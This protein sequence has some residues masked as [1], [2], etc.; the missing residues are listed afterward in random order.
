VSVS[1]LLEL[2]LP[3][4]DVC[5]QADGDTRTIEKSVRHDMWSAPALLVSLDAGTYGMDAA[6]PNNEHKT[7]R[8]PRSLVH[9]TFAEVDVLPA[10]GD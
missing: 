3:R 6:E 7:G 1:R 10:V 4:F 5:Q 8:L 2:V 9:Y